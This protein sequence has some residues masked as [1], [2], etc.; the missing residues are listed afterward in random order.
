MW[1]ERWLFKI[2]SLVHITSITRLLGLR[3]RQNILF[4]C[5]IKNVLPL[6]KVPIYMYQWVTSKR[7]QW[8]R[9]TINIQSKFEV[10]QSIPSTWITIAI[11]SHS[12]NTGGNNYFYN[13][14]FTTLFDIFINKFSLNL[15][16]VCISH[17]IF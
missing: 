11:K 14:Q 9:K 15:K 13:M 1:R 16:L 3:W 2:V 12:I 10:T 6:D 8:N 4:F 17:V 7:H 5:Y